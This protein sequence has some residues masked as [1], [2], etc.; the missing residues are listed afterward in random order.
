MSVG[1]S[2][3]GINEN[4]QKGEYLSCYLRYRFDSF[5]FLIINHHTETE[6]CF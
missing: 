3:K 5:L 1:Q 6:P 4:L 2:T